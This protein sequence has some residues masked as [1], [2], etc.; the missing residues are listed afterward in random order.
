MIRKIMILLLLGAG[1]AGV[2]MVL[3]QK[4]DAA[5]ALPTPSPLTQAQSDNA[6]LPNFDIRL[7]GR[8]EFVDLDL[9]S[10][11]EL[12]IAR[13]SA[14]TSSRAS[15]FEQFRSSARSERAQNVRAVVNEAGAMKNFF[16]D[17][18]TV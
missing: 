2:S 11:S 14:A 8:S 1:I 13:Q 7:V 3:S 10:A 15:A 18:S 4:S 5:R 16:I 17:G 12:Q 6:R 9:T